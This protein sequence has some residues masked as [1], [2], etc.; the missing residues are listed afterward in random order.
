MNFYWFKLDLARLKLIDIPNARYIYFI[1]LNPRT[2]Y[3]LLKEIYFIHF[4]LK[5]RFLQILQYLLKYSNNQNNSENAKGIKGLWACFGPGAAAHRLA[6]WVCWAVA[7]RPPRHH[8]SLWLFQRGHAAGHGRLGHGNH[9]EEDHGTPPLYG[10]PA[11][12][13]WGSNEGE[14][15]ASPSAC[16]SK[17]VADSVGGKLDQLQAPRTSE[18]L[19]QPASRWR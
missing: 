16:C 6:G 5:F 12:R 19:L 8:T 18:G 2:D 14:R 1:F 13:G 10:L 4:C 9:V 7:K 15:E 3:D 17:G 11:W